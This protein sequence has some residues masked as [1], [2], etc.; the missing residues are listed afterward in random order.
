MSRMKKLEVFLL[1]T[2]N[3]QLTPK[4]LPEKYLK[5]FFLFL[6][7]FGIILRLTYYFQDYDLI[8][9]EAN[10]AR[11]LYERNLW[12]L[13]LPLNYEQYAPP[14]F[15]W[16][17]KLFSLV[18]GFSEKA[19]RLYPLLCGI[20]AL[21]VFYKIVN[22]LIPRPAL[23]YPLAMMATGTL[24]VKF[25]AEV[26]QYMPDTMIALF[27]VWVALN[28]DVLKTSKSRFI[29]FWSVIGSI[30]VWTSMSSVFIL[31]GIGCYYAWNLW[32][33]KK[34]KTFWMIMIP[35]LLWV[36]QFLL[37]YFLIL[38]TQISSDYLQRYHQDYFL[39][40]HPANHAQWIHNGQRLMS[41]MGEMGDYTFLALAFNIPLLFL[42]LIHLFR[43][44]KELL[45]L[46]GLPILLVL[47][48]AAFRQYSLIER[49]ILFML[50]LGLVLIGFGFERI[51]QVRFFA[52]KLIISLI[53]VVCIYNGSLIGVLWRYYGFHEITL[54][55]SWLKE[56][57]VDGSHLYIH[58]SSG[59]TYIYYT[60]L[61]PDKNKWQELKGAKILKW[62]TDYAA[63]TKDLRDTVYFLYTGGFSPEERNKRTSQIET[64]MKQV[65][66]FEKYVCFVYEYAQKE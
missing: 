54:G 62:D 60:Q 12:Q 65:D 34:W 22:R 51:I 25:S 49:V 19:L 2:H 56:H 7:L 28:I 59:P 55:L 53:A 40:L 32:R 58:D 26:K 1:T 15:L 16:I 6:L 14:V 5:Y 52:I 30:C 66:Y 20:G 8:I 47:L 10:I 64:N 18:F 21:F 57:H 63:E 45:W 38:K 41:I 11:N 48:A 44:R 36:V 17:E 9:D 23:W 3:S 39:F 50:P 13:C 4:D 31:A 24:Y 27:L 33:D 42:G 35:A 46:F 37:Y 29:L 43:K 61:H